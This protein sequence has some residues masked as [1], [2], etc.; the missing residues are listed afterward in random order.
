MKQISTLLPLLALTVVAVGCG[1]YKKNPVSD[2]EQLRAHGRV[3]T[4][5]GPDAARVV[6]IEKDRPVY[7]QHTTEA[8]TITSDY[9]KIAPDSHMSFNEEQESSYKIR[10]SISL[11]H[12]VMELTA[13]NLPKEAR[14]EKSKEEKD[15]Y[16]LT[17]KPRLYSLPQDKNMKIISV[18]FKADIKSASSPQ[19]L[20]KL[21]SLVLEKKVELSLFKN[22]EL[23]SELTVAGLEKEVFEDSEVSFTVTA[24]VPATDAQTPV[25]PRLVITYDGVNLTAGNNYRELDGSR[26]VLPGNV[27]YMKDGVWKFSLKFDTKKISVQPQLGRD[28]SALAHADGTNVR[29]SFKVLSP[30]GTSTPESL[31]QL[32]IRYTKP[33]PPAESEKPAP[34][35]PAKKEVKS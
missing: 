34:E 19:E 24:K 11:P 21:R 18:T 30:Y 14:L 7:K 27:E 23:P 13:K 6:T 10:A 32:K 33:T 1:E 26:H 20:E 2:L 28:G 5:K 17:W 4:Q 35:T 15:T 25:K 3:E 16:I 29:M 31:M 9:V 22:Q 8:A 12:V